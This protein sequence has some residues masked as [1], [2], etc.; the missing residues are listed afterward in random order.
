MHVTSDLA[1]W[2]G[3]VLTCRGGHPGAVAGGQ[4]RT[5][6]SAPAAHC[7]ARPGHGGCPHSAPAPPQPPSKQWHTSQP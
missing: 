6:D 2:L 1:S 4:N 7:P 3:A 5:P